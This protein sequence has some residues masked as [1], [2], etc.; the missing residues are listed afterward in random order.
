MVRLDVPNLSALLACFWLFDF[1]GGDCAADLFLGPSFLQVCDSPDRFDMH[2]E[3]LRDVAVRE[4][5]RQEQANGLFL[6]R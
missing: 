3:T 1:L 2:S 4:P 5:A 6:L